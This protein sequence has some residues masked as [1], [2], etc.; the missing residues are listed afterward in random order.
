MATAPTS[1]TDNLSPVQEQTL[2]NTRK[3]GKGPKH[4]NA[5]SKNALSTDKLFF[6]VNGG[7]KFWCEQGR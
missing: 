4:E 6:F 2:A 7:Q 1:K 5:C 3:H